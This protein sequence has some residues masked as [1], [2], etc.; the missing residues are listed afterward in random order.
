M[1]RV[2]VS[3]LALLGTSL[4][5]V[6]PRP[7]SALAR[8]SSPRWARAAL[9][10][11][12]SLAA[13]EIDGKHAKPGGGMAPA[14]IALEG[15]DPLTGTA[16]PLV[17]TRVRSRRLSPSPFYAPSW[18]PD[19]ALLAFGGESPRR[20]GVFVV[21][22]D[23]GRPRFVRGTSNG[24]APVFS[25]DGRSI[26]FARG[27]SVSRTTATL[28]GKK[29]SGS[30]SGTTTWIVSAGGGRPHRLTPWRNRLHVI[31]SS[32][33]PDGSTLAVTEARRGSFPRASLLRLADRS[34]RPLASPAE[35]PAF[36][37]DGS[38]I[39]YVGYRPGQVVRASQGRALHVGDVYLMAPDG[40]EARPLLETDGIRE[41]A[42]SWDPSGRRLAFAQLDLGA[43]TVP[44]THLLFP[45]GGAIV[46]VNADGTCPAAI[47]SFPWAAP[48]GP[49]WRPGPGRAAGPI[50]C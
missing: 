39:A 30:F 21:R 28:G 47:R 9:P 12:P 34:R 6:A 40:S 3:C 33:S 2:L 27:K 17:T 20:S 16:Q 36:S 1:I 7:G 15:I 43:G 41:S 18:S 19:G 8:P 29:H 26:A 42:P 38:T 13:V 48:Y 5:V 45:V 46:Q 4:A 31:P 50:V 25:A 35:E 11:G 22:A 24:F 49:A 44:L 10:D 14:A 23:G 37:P 32:F